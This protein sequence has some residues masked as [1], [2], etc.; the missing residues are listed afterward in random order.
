MIIVI[1]IP[2]TAADWFELGVKLS[3]QTRALPPHFGRRGL[4]ITC[5][6]VTIEAV[7]RWWVLD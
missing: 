6:G 5:V 1:V 2:R 7:P 4:T 3:P